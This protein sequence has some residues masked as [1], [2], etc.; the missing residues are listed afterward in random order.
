MAKDSDSGAGQQPTG[1]AAIF[2]REAQRAAEARTGPVGE[3]AYFLRRT[4]KYWMIPLIVALL[5]TS[6]VV[7]GGSSVVA[8]LI[9]ALF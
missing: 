1:R 4:R 5:V 7:V 8:P 6:L 2:E 3:F 9:Y